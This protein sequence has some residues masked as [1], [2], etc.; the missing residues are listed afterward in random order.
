MIHGAFP[1][2]WRGGSGL[3]TWRSGYVADC[4]SAHPGS[5]PGVASIP[6]RFARRVFLPVFQRAFVVRAQPSSRRKCRRC[7]CR[8]SYACSFAHLSATAA[9]SA[10]CSDLQRAS[11]FSLVKMVFFHRI[12]SLRPITACRRSPPSLGTVR[13]V[14]AVIDRCSGRTDMLARSVAAKLERPGSAASML[15]SRAC[16]S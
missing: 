2:C 3:A 1:A 8:Q 6:Q 14:A 10:R 5:I 9:S 11:T 7:R 12:G 16:G 15:L 13:D 4:K